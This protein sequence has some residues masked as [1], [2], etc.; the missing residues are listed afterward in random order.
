VVTN[1]VRDAADR[2]VGLDH[3]LPGSSQDIQ[4]AFARNPASQITGRNLNSL[5]WA[6]SPPSSA[7][8]SYSPDVLNRYSAVGGASLTY[9]GRG[10]LTNDGSRTYAYDFANHLLSTT[11]GGAPAAALAYDPAERLQSVTANG[12]ATRFLYD[13]AKM[14]AD[15]DGSGTL[16]HRYIPGIGTGTPML[17][18]EGASTS[19]NSGSAPSTARWLLADE[20]GS[21]I[22]L[23]NAVGVASINTYGPYGEPTGPI[24]GRFAYTGQLWLPE[25]GSYHFP[26]RDY[27]PRLGRFLQTDPIGYGDGMNLYSYVR[28]DPVNFFDPTGTQ[29]SPDFQKPPE[30]PQKPTT[31]AP[32]PTPQRD[33]S[34]TTPQPVVQPKDSP[35]EKNGVTLKR[36]KPN[37]TGELKKQKEITEAIVDREEVLNNAATERSKGNDTGVKKLEHQAEKDAR[38]IHDLEG[39]PDNPPLIIHADGSTSDGGQVVDVKEGDIAV[40]K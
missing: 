4:F 32:D 36:E 24:D 27:N 17:A 23:S 35:Y 5:S 10:N 7:S 30:E 22:G 21:V 6:W 12:I 18:L 33:P 26:V 16:L 29:T 38:T 25:V 11:G 13:G 37:L 39:T 31:R 2:L 34:D 9:D 28:N 40:P 14:I 8:T 20:R 15:F 1:I 3:D 19:A